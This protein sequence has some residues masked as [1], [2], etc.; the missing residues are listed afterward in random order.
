MMRS[1]G[2][3]ANGRVLSLEEAKARFELSWSKVRE[4]QEQQRPEYSVTRVARRADTE[5]GAASRM[6]ERARSRGRGDQGDEAFR[7]PPGELT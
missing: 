1:Q 3:Y 4:A 7:A 5:S 2:P 6:G